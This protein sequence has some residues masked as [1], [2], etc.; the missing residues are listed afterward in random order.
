MVLLTHTCVAVQNT[1]ASWVFGIVLAH[2]AV[3]LVLL[4]FSPLEGQRDVWHKVMALVPV[5]FNM[6]RR[7]RQYTV[8]L[9]RADDV[10]LLACCLAWPPSCFVS[11]ATDK[12]GA[13]CVV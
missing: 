10:K 2:V 13:W 5:Q 4:R 7:G 8:W 6:G 12:N 11:D 9:P 3:V 1:C